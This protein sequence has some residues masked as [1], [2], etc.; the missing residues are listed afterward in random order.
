[1]AEKVRT[2]YEIFLD[3]LW[4]ENNYSL[5]EISKGIKNYYEECSQDEQTAINNIFVQLTGCSYEDLLDKEERQNQEF[6]PET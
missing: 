2:L 3:E 6:C 1:M 4:T 5:E